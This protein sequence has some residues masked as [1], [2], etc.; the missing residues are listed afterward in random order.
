VDQV[1]KKAD[2]KHER[3]SKEDNRDKFCIYPFFFLFKALVWRA[4][5]KYSQRAT[6]IYLCGYLFSWPC[7]SV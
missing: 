6:W 4:K 5:W 3:S 7:R 2:W 1:A